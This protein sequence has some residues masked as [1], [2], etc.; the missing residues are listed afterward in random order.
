MGIALTVAI[1]VDR[2]DFQPI[3]SQLVEVASVLCDIG[4]LDESERA[5]LLL[6]FSSER[7]DLS[8]YLVFGDRNEVIFPYRVKRLPWI[9]GISEE[10]A[11][12]SDLHEMTI[13]AV[14]EPLT[15][16]DNQTLFTIASQ[17]SLSPV[18]LDKAYTKLDLIR[19]DPLIVELLS[20]MSRVLG[21][22]VRIGIFVHT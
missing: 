4:V 3:W 6:R 13:R 1:F 16:D 14:D 8:G 21:N 10:A 2:S 9:Y 15:D 12:P 5:R 7:Y 11:E 20:K 18:D 19:R 22:E 17:Q